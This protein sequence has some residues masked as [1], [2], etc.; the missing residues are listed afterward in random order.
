MNITLILVGKTTEKYINEGFKIYHERVKHYNSFEIKV[1]PEIKFN[2]SQTSSYIKTAE[3]Q[4]IIK[5]IQTGDYVILLDEQGNEKTSR[6]LAQFL[7]NKV[8]SGIRNMLFV[9]GGA[10]GFSEAVYQRADLKLSLSKMTF[11]H[12]L[13]RLVFIEQL[14]RAFTIIR[15]EKYH[16]D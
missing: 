9:I 14:Y 4:A 6:D 10:Y 7:N 5:N 11:P 8:V 16:H 2:K 1:I 15:N 12:Q 13:V 3:G